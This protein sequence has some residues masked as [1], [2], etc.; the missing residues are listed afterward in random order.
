MHSNIGKGSHQ[1]HHFFL[2]DFYTANIFVYVTTLC[3]TFIFMKRGG[4][5]LNDKDIT[6]SR[7]PNS[8]AGE[9]KTEPLTAEKLISYT[10]CFSFLF[11]FKPFDIGCQ[12]QQQTTLM[13]WYTR[14]R[15]CGYIRRCFPLSLIG[16]I[17]FGRD[18]L[19]RIR[20]LLNEFFRVTHVFCISDG[21]V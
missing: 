19:F 4:R 14:K 8:L 1:L 10:S 3:Y 15:T 2:F 6:H 11:C 21:R 20:I 17:S 16:F 5:N 7:K 12:N 13:I 18:E 9:Q